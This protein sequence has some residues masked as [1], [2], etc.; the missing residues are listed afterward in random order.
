M[1]Y[2]LKKNRKKIR[3]ALKA[4]LQAD[5]YP[6]ID[7]IFT[8]STTQIN[9]IRKAYRERYPGRS[10]YNDVKDKTTGYTQKVASGIIAKNS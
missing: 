1:L 9:D 5:I 2:R 7:V 3:T 10:L 6:L 4:P 8:K